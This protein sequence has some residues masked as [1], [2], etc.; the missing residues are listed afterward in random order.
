M[1]LQFLKCIVSLAIPVKWVILFIVKFKNFADFKHVFCYLKMFD[2]IV[3]I[4]NQN[5]INNKLI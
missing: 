5:S 2:K 1:T 3:K 4:I